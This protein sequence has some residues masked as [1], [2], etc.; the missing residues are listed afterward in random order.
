MN[1]PTTQPPSAFLVVAMSAVSLPPDILSVVILGIAGPVLGLAFL[2][3]GRVVSGR[4]WYRLPALLAAGLGGL[5]LVSLVCGL[6]QP[7]WLP[8]LALSCTCALF[9]LGRSPLPGQMGR[10]AKAAAGHRGVQAGLLL[11]GGPLLLV[12]QAYRLEGE[13][14]P[15]L[16]EPDRLTLQDV[17][18]H[19]AV[20]LGAVTD[21]GRP[22]PLFDA[23]PP[24]GP[25]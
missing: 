13:T 9:G 7:F 1:H 15:V 5:G 4:R 19:E 24:E 2:V 22:V 23:A 11:A 3:W 20:D 6:E 16:L 18:L 25:A 14:P 17:R 8:P 12:W 10:W 21:A